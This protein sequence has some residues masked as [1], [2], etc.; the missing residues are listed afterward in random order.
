MPVT[1]PQSRCIDMRRFIQ[2]RHA[3]STRHVSFLVPGYGICQNREVGIALCSKAHPLH[4]VCGEA[5]VC[6]EQLR[7][8]YYRVS[9]HASNQGSSMTPHLSSTGV[10]MTPSPLFVGRVCP[11]YRMPLH[12]PH[13]H[14]HLR[15]HNMHNIDANSAVLRSLNISGA[16]FR[17]IPWYTLAVGAS[18][19]K[20]IVER[21]PILDVYLV[22]R[23]LHR[24]SRTACWNLD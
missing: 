10:R 4:S 19:E 1:E 21:S 22:L 3:K 5:L 2:E 12:Y 14:C 24:M 18:M 9:S 8:S 13:T 11:P 16:R 17:G 20:I 6:P 15:S 7:P 23:I